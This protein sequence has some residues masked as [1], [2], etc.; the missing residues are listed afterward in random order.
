MILDSCTLLVGKQS[1]AAAME[2]SMEV[3]KKL[4]QND[5]MI[6]QSHFWAFIQKN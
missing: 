2:N 4:K 5:R 6:Q 3:P 1:G